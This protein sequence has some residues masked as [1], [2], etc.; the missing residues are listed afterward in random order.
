MVQKK[1]VSASFFPDCPIAWARCV[2]WWAEY[3]DAAHAQFFLVRTQNLCLGMHHPSFSSKRQGQTRK[4][5]KQTVQKVFVRSAIRTHLLISCPLFWGK[6][7]R[8]FI[9]SLS[10]FFGTFSK[11]K[12]KRFLPMKVGSNFHPFSCTCACKFA[13]MSPSQGKPPWKVPPQNDFSSL[14]K[15]TIWQKNLHNWYPSWGNIRKTCPNFNFNFFLHS[16]GNFLGFRVS[17]GKWDQVP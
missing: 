8:V 14:A 5:K 10:N 9:H 15:K 6:W 3:F 17:S 2:W 16:F 4:K 7:G 11:G 13:N 1:V 12:P